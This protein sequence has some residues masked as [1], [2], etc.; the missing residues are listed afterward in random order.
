MFAAEIRRKRIDRMR[1]FSN[2]CWHVDELFVRINGER[3]Y[4]WRA[5]DPRAK[6]SR[7]SSRSAG[8]RA[9]H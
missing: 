1:A 3:C 4:L 8:A 9:P 6:C 2:W 5:V 7:R